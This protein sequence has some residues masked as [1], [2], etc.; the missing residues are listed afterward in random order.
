MSY[1]DLLTD[2][3]RGD[4]LTLTDEQLHSKVETTFSKTF[5]RMGITLFVAFGLAYSI[6]MGLVAI[7]LTFWW[8]IIASLGGFG[9]IIRMQTRRQ[10]MSYSMLAGLLLLF[11]LL[12]GYWLSWVFLAYNLWSVYN[13][14]LSTSV[15][16]LTLAVIGY[17]TKIDIS[18]VGW[19]LS[20][21]LIALLISMI[22]NIFR[23]NQTFSLWL[24]IAGVVIFS[25]MTI[26]EVASLKQMALVSDERMEIIMALSLFLTFINLFMFLLRLF[27]GSSQD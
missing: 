19:I 3:G 9:L 7:P 6:A 26:Y 12:Q 16:F 22:I 5:M 14:F 11:G 25:G 27:G 23:A 13:V 8:S 15:L 10:S 17:T 1:R 4:L 20:T 18:R 2:F 24:N 21:A